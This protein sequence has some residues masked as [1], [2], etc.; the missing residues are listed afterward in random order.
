MRG[1]SG[2]GR[3]YRDLRSD[4]KVDAGEVEL[5]CNEEDDHPDRAEYKNSDTPRPYLRALRL[6]HIANSSV[7]CINRLSMARFIEA[8]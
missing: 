7:L 2:D 1:A 6:A 8:P 5:A 3:P 4:V